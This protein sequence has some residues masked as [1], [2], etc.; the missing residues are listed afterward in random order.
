[1]SVSA[2]TTKKKKNRRRVVLTPLITAALRKTSTTENWKEIR[3]RSK[4]NHHDPD[5]GFFAP[6]YCC[7]VDDDEFEQDDKNK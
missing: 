1:V 7:L 4:R 3:G 6:G 5:S 2:T